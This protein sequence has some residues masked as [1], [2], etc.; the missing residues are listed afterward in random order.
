MAS[1]AQLVERRNVAP[2]VMGSSPFAR[3]WEYSSVVEQWPV[4][5]FVVGSI[6]SIP[7]N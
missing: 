4:K 2:E 1:I 6:P 3:P 5:P 7:A